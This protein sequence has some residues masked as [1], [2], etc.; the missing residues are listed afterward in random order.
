MLG[1]LVGQVQEQGV[2]VEQVVVQH[3]PLRPP[4]RERRRQVLQR[5]PAALAFEHQ[6]PQPPDPKL[7]QGQ[8]VDVFLLGVG[9]V[10]VLLRPPPLLL[11]VGGLPPKGKKNQ[12]PKRKAAPHAMWCGNS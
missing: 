2:V 1:D 8:L 3:R 9:H 6:P 10:V 11:C 4:L 5:G 7:Q 12:V